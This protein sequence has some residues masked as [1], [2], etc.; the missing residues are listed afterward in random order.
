MSLQW[1]TRI[2]ARTNGDQF[3]EEKFRH[4]ADNINVVLPLN[5]SLRTEYA[6]KHRAR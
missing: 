3:D 1:E 4:L 6:F 2:K 5:M